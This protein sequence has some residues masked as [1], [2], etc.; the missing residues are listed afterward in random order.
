MIYCNS[1]KN[2]VFFQKFNVLSKNEIN[3]LVNDI[4]YE[5]REHLCTT[6]PLFQTYPNLHEK[7][8]HKTSWKTFFANVNTFVNECYS[9]HLNNKINFKIESCWANVS[10]PE[11]NYQVHTHDIELL[12]LV[13][14]LKNTS[15]ECGTLLYFEDHCNTIIGG[16]ENSMLLFDGN[17]PH[18]IVSSPLETLLHFPRYSIALDFM[19]D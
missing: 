5:I 18:S 14:Y 3:D 17:I 13:F 2:S 7:Y 4:D 1:F 8:H 19:Y 15:K 11:S 9:K 12:T 10:K 16:E 6:V